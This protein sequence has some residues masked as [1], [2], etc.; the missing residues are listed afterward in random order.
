MAKN[1]SSP[2]F[3]VNANKRLAFGFNI[4][5]LY[6]RG[7]YPDQATAFFNAGL[8]ASYIGERYQIQA[9]YNNF[10][11]KMNENGGI[12]DDQYVTRPENMPD[13][14]GWNDLFSCQSGANIEPQS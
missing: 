10:S 5:Y 8:F 2:I 3:Q 6:G 4:D 13:V 14:G 7:Y 1:G 11:L 9:M 12:A